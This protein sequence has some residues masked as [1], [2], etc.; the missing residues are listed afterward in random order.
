MKNLEGPSKYL[1]YYALVAKDQQKMYVCTSNNWPHQVRNHLDPL[2]ACP[3]WTM[4]SCGLQHAN[5]VTGWGE[6]EPLRSWQ[7]SIT[8]P[9]ICWPQLYLLVLI[10]VKITPIIQVTTRS[11]PDEI[12]FKTLSGNYTTLVTSFALSLSK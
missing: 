12:G 9:G 6:E 2:T 5:N 3:E 4:W 1:M 10:E 11:M 7:R 8:G